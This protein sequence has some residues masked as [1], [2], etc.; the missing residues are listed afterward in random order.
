[1]SSSSTTD[2]FF[3]ELERRSLYCPSSFD[4][5]CLCWTFHTLYLDLRDSATI[6][7]LSLFYRS[8]SF[9]CC[10]D[11]LLPCFLLSLRSRFSIFLLLLIISDSHH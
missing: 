11:R 6:S 5:F 9:L 1:S 2:C 4:F 10:I 3:F 7:R 8:F